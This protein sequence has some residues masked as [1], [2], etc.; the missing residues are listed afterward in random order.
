[1][2]K[3]TAII[4][5]LIFMTKIR[6]TAEYFGMSVGFVGNPDQI[7]FYLKG[8]ELILIDLE[9]DFVD[10]INLIEKLKGNP[11]T[12]SIKLIAYLSHANTPLKA[13]ALAAGSDEVISRFEFNSNLREIL[14]AACC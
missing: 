4:N 13:Q 6:N 8:C 5:D 9:N 11:A 12:A 14:Q 2:A 10:S 7:D 3:V 1:M